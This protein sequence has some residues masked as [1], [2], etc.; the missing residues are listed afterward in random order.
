MK[1]RLDIRFSSILLENEFQVYGGKCVHSFSELWFFKFF[2][3]MCMAT[4]SG[5]N[6]WF[7]KGN[8]GKINA[9]IS[10]EIG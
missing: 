5:P 7:E 4:F 2:I 10:T 3:D 6:E 9:L 1:I 8:R